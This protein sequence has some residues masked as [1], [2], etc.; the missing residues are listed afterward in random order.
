MVLGWNAVADE[1]GVHHVFV[2]AGERLE[3]R[4]VQIGRH[5]GGQVEVVRGLAAGEKVA[6][7]GTARLEDGVLVAATSAGE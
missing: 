7:Q 1:D 4:L 6:V 2:V 3:K 5:V